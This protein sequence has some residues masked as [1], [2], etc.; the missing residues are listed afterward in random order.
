MPNYEYE[1]RACEV[2]F[3][4]LLMS[5][6]E[7]EKY[8]KEHPCP[9][10]KQLAPRIMSRTNFQFKGVAEGDPTRVGN[11]GVHDLDYPKL[12]KAVGRSANRKWKEY[13]ARKEARDRARRDLGTNAVSIGPRGEIQATDQKTLK[14]RETGIKTWQ[15]ALEQN[16]D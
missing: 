14:A 1:C 7:V 13:D 15:K 16:P 9:Q 3:E 8:S 5:R 4:E 12:D 10:C 2:V 11:S 6:E